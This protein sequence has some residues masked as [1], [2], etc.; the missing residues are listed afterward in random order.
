MRLCDNCAGKEAVMEVGV[1]KPRGHQ[2]H[3]EQPRIDLCTPCENLLVQ[4]DFAGLAS[5]SMTVNIQRPKP[6]ATDIGGRPIET[7]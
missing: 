3:E 2:M 6:P 5:R 1:G 7:L 4:G